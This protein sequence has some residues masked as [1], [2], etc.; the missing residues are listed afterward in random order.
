[1]KSSGIPTKRPEDYFAQMIKTDAHMKKVRETLVG[2]QESLE[3][4][5][6]AKKLREMKKMGK[7]IQIEVTKK[8]A[9]EKREMIDR[10]NKFKKGKT[11]T[12]D[13]EGPAKAKKKGKGDNKKDFKNDKYGYG[14]AKKRGKYNT[15]D[16]AADAYGGFKRGR[17]GAANSKAKGG[18]KPRLGK[19][20][21]DKQRNSRK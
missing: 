21:R 2:K 8:R 1:M 5:E 17:N 12:L 20:K 3:K 15:A 6:K 14:G 4:S 13:L 10:V 16:S 19:N 7:Q 18:K 11:A 9:K